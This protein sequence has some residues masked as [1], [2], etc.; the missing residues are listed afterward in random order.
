MYPDNED[1]QKSKY[2]FLIFLIV[3]VLFIA[4]V[5][6]V[7]FLWSVSP[8]IV[9]ILVGLCVALGVP[10]VAGVVLL[11]VIAEAGDDGW[12]RPNQYF[13]WSTAPKIRDRWPRDK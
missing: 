9:L 3:F 6:L 5:C 12:S 7:V 13:D 4:F 10:V 8:M 11:V 1:N 2:G